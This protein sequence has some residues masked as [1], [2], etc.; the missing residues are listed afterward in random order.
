MAD[1]DETK[2]ENRNTFCWEPMDVARELKC[3]RRTVFNLVHKDLIPYAKVGR[4]LR[5]C[6]TR[7]EEWLAAGG[8]RW[9]R[10]ARFGRPTMTGRK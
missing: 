7:I 8:T 9:G 3:S 4:L 10:Q 6:P 1:S 5:F 2:K